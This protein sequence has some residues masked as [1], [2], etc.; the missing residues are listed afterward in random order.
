MALI[1]FDYGFK[2]GHCWPSIT[3]LCE[4]LGG[5]LSRRRIYAALAWMVEKKLIKRQAPRTTD[6]KVNKN[7]FTLILR[8]TYKLVQGMMKKASQKI[9]EGDTGE[10]KSSI[11]SSLRDAKKRT[12][13]KR[14]KKNIYTS[15]R[16]QER[17]TSCLE[18]ERREKQSSTDRQSTMTNGE[19]LFSKIL[20]GMEMMNPETKKILRD[21]GKNND[22]FVSWM[23]HQHPDWFVRI[24]A[25]ENC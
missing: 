23:Q 17:K 22:E 6:G 12:R 15:R 7:R 3:S 16:S 20:Q 5:K 24:Y 19:R 11:T 9:G 13:R 1:S 10:S 8:K 2:K 21:E 25:T 14:T 18:K 4:K